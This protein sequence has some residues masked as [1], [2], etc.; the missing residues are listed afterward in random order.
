MGDEKRKSPDVDSE[1]EHYV[2]ETPKETKRGSKGKMVGTKPIKSR[3]P[4]RCESAVEVSDID[5][6]ELPRPVWIKAVP[7]PDFDEIKRDE[8]PVVEGAVTGGQSSS[9]IVPGSLDLTC[10]V[11]YKEY[12]SKQSLKKHLRIH[13]PNAGGICMFCFKKLKHKNN[14][15]AHAVT[16]AGKEKLNK[17]LDAQLDHLITPIEEYGNNVNLP[18]PDIPG[19][20]DRF[21][22]VKLDP[23]YAESIS[24]YKYPY[25]N[26]SSN[27]TY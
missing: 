5:P 14:V 23:E 12:P 7:T 11:C 19:T 2:R 10:D 4:K 17:L 8:L 25:S 27:I 13:K 3:N 20:M 9:T 15:A 1:S 18:V 24:L 16:C 22:R 21:G 26:V 6:N